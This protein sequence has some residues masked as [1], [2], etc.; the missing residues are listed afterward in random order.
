MS[1]IV[2]VRTMACSNVA[3][4]GIKLCVYLKSWID[5]GLF[6]CSGTNNYATHR[7]FDR[8]PGDLL[9][10]VF[11]DKQHTENLAASAFFSLVRVLHML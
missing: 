2:S 3:S 10:H 8:V 11:G 6:D 4:K 7:K 5:T 9:L 1:K